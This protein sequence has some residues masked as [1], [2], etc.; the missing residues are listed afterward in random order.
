MNTTSRGSSGGT[1]SVA[2]LSA[3]AAGG[4]S[5]GRDELVEALVKLSRH[6]ETGLGE[7]WRCGRLK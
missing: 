1:A 7:V 5:L 2:S 6:D 3:T 4:L